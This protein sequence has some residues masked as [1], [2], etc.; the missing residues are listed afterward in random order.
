[1]AGLWSGCAA[2]SAVAV[3]RWSVSWGE[4][5][6]RGLAQW[7]RSYFFWCG[8]GHSTQIGTLGES[9]G[10]SDPCPSLLDVA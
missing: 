8:C 5:V 4:H 3:S 2:K 6:S 1:M 7:L 9:R 10:L